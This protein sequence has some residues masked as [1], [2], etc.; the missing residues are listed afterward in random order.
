MA[1]TKVFPTFFE[2]AY[3]VDFNDHKI[4][5]ETI[6]AHFFFVILC[7]YCGLIFVKRMN[8]RVYAIGVL[9]ALQE[10]DLGPDDLSPFERTLLLEKLSFLPPE[11]KQARSR[12]VCFVSRL[13]R[14]FW[15]F[16]LLVLTLAVW[17]SMAFSVYFGQFMN[18]S[19]VDWL[20]QPMIQ[21]PYIRVPEIHGG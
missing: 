13:L 15:T 2:Q 9:N 17:C 20:N 4:L 11:P 12:W 5:E 7:F 3:K 14:K 16:T 19:H 8:A 21:M 6:F 1:G 18:L 10:K